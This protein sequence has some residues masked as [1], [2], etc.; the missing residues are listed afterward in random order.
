MLDTELLSNGF[1]LMLVGMGMV[2]V[3]LSVLVFVTILM[4]RFLGEPPVTVISEVQRKEQI[5]SEEIAAISSA[6]HTYRNKNSKS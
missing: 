6:I 5:S 4:Q 3:F 2:F 1:Q